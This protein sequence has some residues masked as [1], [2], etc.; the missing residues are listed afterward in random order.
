MDN[1]EKLSRPGTQDEDK[2]NKKHNIICVRHHTQTNTN[3]VNKTW[4]L[5]QRTGS[6]DELNIVFM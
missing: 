6:K 5:F 2:L 4:T 3:K 1:T